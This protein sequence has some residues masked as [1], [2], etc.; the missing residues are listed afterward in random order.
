MVRLILDSTGQ[1]RFPVLQHFEVEE[2]ALA[3]IR[4]IPCTRL[5]EIGTIAVRPEHRKGPAHMELVKVIM[6]TTW[7]RG[8]RFVLSC[9]DEGY[10]HGLLRKGLFCRPIGPAKMYM[11]S[12]TVPVLFDSAELPWKY[13]LLFFVYRIWGRFYSA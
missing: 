8:V 3:R 1:Y 7:R 6:T 5:V 13:R 9:I 11:G 12:V 10:F 4:K 2:A